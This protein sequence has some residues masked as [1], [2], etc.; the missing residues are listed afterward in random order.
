MKPAFVFF[1]LV[2]CLVGCGSTRQSASSIPT[3]AEHFADLYAEQ[4]LTLLVMPPINRSTKVEAKELMYSSL[5]VPLAGKGYYV[6]PAL[7]TQE[8][9]R[10]ESAYDAELFVEQSLKRFGEIFGVDAV[11]FT[12]IHQWTKSS[13]TTEVTVTVEYQLK[14]AK[15][16]KLLFHRKGTIV[17]TPKTDSGHWLSDLL[18][19]VL[20]TAMKKEIDLA[21]TCHYN[22]FSDLP[23]GIYRPEY[24]QDGHLRV[25]SESFTI[26]LE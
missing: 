5:T 9:L 16:D 14:S 18:S 2:L 21:R 19:D 10:Q 15:T 20:L 7:L 1:P 26:K 23:C 8:I 13:I 12:T 22:A 17:Y 24:Q 11:L 4:P 3:R 25:G 6:L